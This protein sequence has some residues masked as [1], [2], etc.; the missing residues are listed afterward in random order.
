MPKTIQRLLAEEGDKVTCDLCPAF[1]LFSADN[2]SIDITLLAQVGEN[3]WHFY[4]D[5]NGDRNRG[6]VEG[7]TLPQSYP[8]QGRSQKVEEERDAVSHSR[9]AGRSSVQVPS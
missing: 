4:D 3:S 1:Q 9:S 7:P 8:K 2:R 5:E 6:P